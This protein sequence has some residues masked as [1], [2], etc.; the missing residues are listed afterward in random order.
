MCLDDEAGDVGD[1]CGV[2]EWFWV[3]SIITITP[4]SLQ[5]LLSLCLLLLSEM[6]SQICETGCYNLVL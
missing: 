5:L 4:K 3:P 6:I 1:R 2:R